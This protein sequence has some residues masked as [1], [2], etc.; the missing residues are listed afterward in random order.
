MPKIRRRKPH[1]FRMPASAGVRDIAPVY[2]AAKE[3]AASGRDVTVVCEGLTRCDAAGL[4]VLLALR[5]QVLAEGRKFEITRIPEEMAWRFDFVGL[6]TRSA[7][8]VAGVAR[9]GDAL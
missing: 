2:D 4:Q 1:T 3:A 8:E 6:A 5:A 7:A 9:A